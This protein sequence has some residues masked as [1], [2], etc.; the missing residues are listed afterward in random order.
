[1]VFLKYRV[2]KSHYIIR[3]IQSNSKFLAKS[4]ESLYAIFLKTLNASSKAYY[5]KLLNMPFV[6]IFHMLVFKR[7]TNGLQLTLFG[8]AKDALLRSY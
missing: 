7:P 2:I 8:L 1:M 4:L 5:S 3:Y 6:L